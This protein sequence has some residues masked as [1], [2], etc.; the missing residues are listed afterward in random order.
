MET[1]RIVNILGTEYIIDKRK[2]DEDENFEKKKYVAYIDTDTKNI[3]YLDMSTHP[4][5]IASGTYKDS[6]KC[7][8]SENAS[9]RHE[10]THAFMYESGLGSCALNAE[11]PWSEN[12]EMIDWFA[13][14]SPKIY[15]VFRE[16][17]LL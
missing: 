1:S 9:L 3:V 8:S 10:I 17:M 6:H 15:K 12:E 7:K 16:L 14:Q 11:L 2:Y 5:L 13:I 4:E